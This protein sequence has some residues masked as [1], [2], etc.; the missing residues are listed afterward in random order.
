[1]EDS[2]DLGGDSSVV[3]F[4]REHIEWVYANLGVEEPQEDSAPGPGAFAWLLALKTDDKAL[5]EFYKTVMP[6]LLPKEVPSADAHRELTGANQV[7][8]CDELLWNLKKEA[9]SEGS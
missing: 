8:T 9:E 6:R 2:S 1:M 7:D 5:G 3:P 4:G